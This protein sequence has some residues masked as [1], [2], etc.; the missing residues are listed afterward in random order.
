MNWEQQRLDGVWLGRPQIHNDERGRFT[1]IFRSSHTPNGA[2]EAFR[3]V[4]INLSESST[5]VLRGLHVTVGETAQA[6]YVACVEGEIF[7]VLVDLR[8]DSP[9]FLESVCVSLTSTDLEVLLVPPGVGHGFMAMTDRCIVMYSVTSE[10]DPEVEVRINPL[11]PDLG[12]RWP[13]VGRLVMSPL[14][15]TAPSIADVLANGIIAQGLT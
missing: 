7:D 12:L 13:E 11:D 1:E 5:G 8:T 15:A 2:M 3:P 14:D 9:S 10:Y 4:Q 6:K